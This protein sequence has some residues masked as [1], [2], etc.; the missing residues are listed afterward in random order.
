MKQTKRD[1]YEAAMRQLRE[2]DFSAW[3]RERALQDEREGKCVVMRK[4][5]LPPKRLPRKPSWA[6]D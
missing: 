5:E 1:E 4:P 6:L 2:E 3:L